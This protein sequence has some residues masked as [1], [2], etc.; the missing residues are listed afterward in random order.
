MYTQSS[1]LMFTQNNQPTLL[2][3]ADVTLLLTKTMPPLLGVCSHLKDTSILKI[4]WL[5]E[6]TP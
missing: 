1:V 3:E 4:S 2:P 6:V 5:E